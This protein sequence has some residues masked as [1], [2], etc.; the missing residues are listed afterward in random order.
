MEKYDFPINIE[1]GEKLNYWLRGR[2]QCWTL[3]TSVGFQI[4]FPTTCNAKQCYSLYSTVS[5]NSVLHIELT[6]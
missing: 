5:W 4:Q 3:K 2:V 1:V 6:L